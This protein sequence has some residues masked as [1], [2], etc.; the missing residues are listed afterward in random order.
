MDEKGKPGSTTEME[1][2]HRTPSAR[3][4]EIQL[5]LNK[6]H[7][8]DEKGQED[9][10]EQTSEQKQTPVPNSETAK[11]TNT[12]KSKETRKLQAPQEGTGLVGFQ[13]FID[14]LPGD[15]KQGMES[16][17]ERK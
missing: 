11:G 2:G 1:E 7:N 14:K 8:S 15:I 12:E 16:E 5:N 17:K 9:L 3:N 10:K 6:S 4:F 13:S